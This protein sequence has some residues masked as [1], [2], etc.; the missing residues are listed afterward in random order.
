MQHEKLQFP[1]YA[2]HL[3]PVWEIIKSMIL[4]TLGLVQKQE[5][6]FFKPQLFL[7]VLEMFLTWAL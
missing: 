1:V 4:E 2:T 6:G 5:K 3:I 7:K